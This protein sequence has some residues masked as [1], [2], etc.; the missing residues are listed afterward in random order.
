MPLLVVPTPIGNMEDITLRAL[1]VLKE[2]D[3]IACEDTRRTM[4][5]L[6]RYGIR[7]PLLSYHSFN[8]K[9]RARD[10]AERLSRGETVALV[11]DAGTPGISDPG[12][13]LIRYS[14]EA[15]YEVDVLPGPTAVV[16]ALLLS[17]FPPRPFLFEGFLPKRK[18]ERRR[19]LEELRDFG[20]TIVFYLSPHGP[21]KVLGDV[22]EVLGN[23]PAVILREISKLHQERIPG[24]LASLLASLGEGVLKGELVLVTG[25][26]AVR[27][28]TGGDDCEE[29]LLEMLE[30]GL[31]E[32]EVVRRLVEEYGISKNK[33]KRLLLGKKREKE[34]L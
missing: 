13:E 10:L 21:V 23:R 18:G 22:L 8:E 24:D 16:P 28:G 12:Y 4:K 11:S 32:K 26:A 15:G 19:R 29:A 17:G 3:V 6:S 7:T 30:G 5:I 25:P 9:E 31:P 20:G 34:A 1:R 2:A 14:L 27:R 33:A